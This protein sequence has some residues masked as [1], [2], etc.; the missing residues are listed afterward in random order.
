M[1]LTFFI[2]SILCHLK[3]IN[4]VKTGRRTKGEVVT[5]KLSYLSN[6]DFPCYSLIMTDN[7]KAETLG[8][9]H[10]SKAK[11]IQSDEECIKDTYYCK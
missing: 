4:V 3:L 1:R 9:I 10:K 8:D 6:D 11:L 7:F 2:L 5:I